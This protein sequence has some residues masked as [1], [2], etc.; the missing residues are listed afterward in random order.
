M[1]D[2]LS[3]PHSQSSGTV[4]CTAIEGKLQLHCIYGLEIHLTH[5]LLIDSEQDREVERV[6]VVEG[7]P[8]RGHD[9]HF[10]ICK[11]SRELRGAQVGRTLQETS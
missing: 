1:I 2:L 9:L 7:A 5:Q 4:S 11:L 3:G 10:L 6:L 8:G